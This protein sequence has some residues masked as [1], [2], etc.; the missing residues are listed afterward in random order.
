MKAAIYDRYGGPE[1]LTIREVETPSARETD[2]LVRVR[3]AAVTMGDIWRT[4]HRISAAPSLKRPS[5]LGVASAH[6]GWGIATHLPRAVIVDM[7]VSQR[8][9]HLDTETEYNVG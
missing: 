5:P 1:V 2:I 3:A 6:K 4:R 8:P 9:L 7:E